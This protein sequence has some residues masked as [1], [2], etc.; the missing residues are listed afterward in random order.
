MRLNRETIHFLVAGKLHRS[1]R[2]QWKV[3]D[4]RQR[5]IGKT[6]TVFTSAVI[7]C[8][9]VG[10]L[11]SKCRG[12]GDGINY[13]GPPRRDLRRTYTSVEEA[14][15]KTRDDYVTVFTVRRKHACL[16]VDRWEKVKLIGYLNLL[17]CSHQWLNYYNTTANRRS[18]SPGGATVSPSRYRH[19][20]PE[21]KFSHNSSYFSLY[22]K[23]SF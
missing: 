6:N 21:I 10:L 7:G 11:L 18:D 1:N 5:V 19:C 12:C 22:N 2:V 3:D 4:I 14:I 13:C 20:W 23:F 16:T 8:I 15:T 9:R 17:K